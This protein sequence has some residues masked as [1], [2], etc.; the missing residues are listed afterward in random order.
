M[1]GCLVNHP[2]LHQKLRLTMICQITVGSDDSLE[3]STLNSMCSLS[4][5]KKEH[6]LFFPVKEMRSPTGG[7]AQI[8]LLQYALDLSTIFIN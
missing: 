1:A 8:Q 7:C 4:P 3:T 6:K 5:I 2:E